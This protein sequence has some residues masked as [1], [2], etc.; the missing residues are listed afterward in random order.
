MQQFRGAATCA[1]L[2]LSCLSLPSGAVA[3]DV[4]LQSFDGSV[5]I[6]GNLIS[7]DGAYYRID[8]IYGP[9][10]ISAQG[11]DC[12]GPGC[13]DLTT[14]MAEASIAGT[15]TV[16]EG[17]LP[18]LLEGFANA[19]GMR[20]VARPDIEGSVIYDLTRRTGSPAARF[21]VTPGT[22]DDGFLSLLNGEADMALALREPTEV[23]QRADRAEAPDDPALSRRVRVLAL[24]ALVPVI[25]PQNPLDAITLPDLAR[26]FGGEIDNWA[27]LGGP[28]APVARHL[29]DPGLGLSQA[30]ASRV[31]LPE[32]TETGTIIRH[33][34]A[35]DLASAVARDAYAIGISAQSARGSARSLD[36]SGSCGLSQSATANA[37]KA[38]DYPLTAPVFLYLA[39]RRL[40]QLVRDFLAYTE[41]DAAERIVADAGF[42][43]QALTRTPLALQGER[44]ANAIEAAGEDIALEDLQIMLDVLRGAERLSSTF[45]FDAGVV[46][47]DAQ[48]RA[49][50]A[51]LAAAIE[52]GAFDG[53]Q[54]IF[55]G[56]SDGAGSSTVNA[57]L[58]L[59]RAEAVRDAVL[60]AAGAAPPDRVELRVEGFGEA[61]PMACDDT[62]WG[63]AVNRRVEVW[64]Q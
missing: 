9:L 3:Q 44:L 13:P 6:E 8:T 5:E 31:V 52:R 21:Y 41:T 19:Q 57:R 14:F 30:F 27:E 62:D 56:F 11:V 48:S 24:D 26:L 60:A 40:P 32:D 47:L 46:D 42:V 53:R 61:L 18:A 2:F 16:A 17:L 51:R 64:V 4:A 54:L 49:S 7:Y 55:A 1:A 34:S 29:L 12:A 38:E 50:A 37:V 10:T 63:R 22:S 25:A 36:L 58:S 35:L 28:D 45:R 15:A 39:P 23:E 20:L 33:D 43:N 59:R